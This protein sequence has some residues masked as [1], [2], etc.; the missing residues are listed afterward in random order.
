MSKYRE[1]LSKD[2]QSRYERGSI[3]RI[4]DS[5]ETTDKEILEEAPS[6]RQFL[7]EEA[8]Q[9]LLIAESHS[10]RFD[11]LLQLLDEFSIPYTIDDNLVR[12]LDYYDNI[13]FEFKVENDTLIVRLL[14]VYQI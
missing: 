10:Q 4:L 1:S 2:S 6:I 11:S 14:A 3:L 12:G 9:V 5:K 8:N 7:S 13:V